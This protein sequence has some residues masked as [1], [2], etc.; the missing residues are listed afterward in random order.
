MTLGSG[1]ILRKLFAQKI[2]ILHAGKL[3]V[4]DGGRLLAVPSPFL[5]QGRVKLP[6]QHVDDVIS[7]NRKEL[8]A[9]EGSACGHVESVARGVR[10]N[11][12]VLARGDGVPGW[13]SLDVIES[14]SS[15]GPRTYQ[16]I[17]KFSIGIFSP[18]SAPNN[19]RRAQRTS[20]CNDSGTSHCASL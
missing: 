17:R 9:V 19:D 1:V 13:V 2:F 10:R 15:T 7:K 18:T 6:V 5:L 3:L 12:K 4:R 20:S 16:Q 8:E 11:D 14:G